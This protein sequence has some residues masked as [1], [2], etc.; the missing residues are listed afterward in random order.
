MRAGLCLSEEFGTLG[1]CSRVRVGSFYCERDSEP[2]TEAGGYVRRSVL[3]SMRF[4]GF[5]WL[6]KGLGVSRSASG[7]L[8]RGGE[9]GATLRRS[10][11]L[12]NIAYPMLADLVHAVSHTFAGWVWPEQ[13]FPAGR[14]AALSIPRWWIGA[15][16]AAF[17]LGSG[18]LWSA[19]RMVGH[20][21]PPPSPKSEE[22][23]N[24]EPSVPTEPI[25]RL[26]VAGSN[27]VLTQDNIRYCLF[28]QVRLE[29][30][31]PLTAATDLTIFDALASDWNARCARAQYP[32]TER[33][34]IGA[35]L[36]TR[37]S[38]L[39]AQGREFV[40]RWRRRMAVRIGST[41]SGAVAPAAAASNSAQPPFKEM[42]PEMSTLPAAVTA[43]MF[44][45]ETVPSTPSRPP[46]LMLLHTYVAARVQR[47]LNELGYTIAPADGTWG[48]MSRTA[49]RRFK[50]A[51]GLL[52]DDALDAET[53]ARLFS[54]AAVN[55][56]PQGR[57]EP[58]NA[59]LTFEA[60]YPPPPG[61]TMNPLNR[62]DASWIQRRLAV[63]GYYSGDVGLWTAGS[64]AA[65]REFKL[66][67]HLPN[68]D[69][70]DAATEAAL[71]SE[72]PAAASDALVAR[73]P[74][75]PVVCDTE[76]AAAGDV[77]PNI[78]MKSEDSPATGDLRGR[79]RSDG[80][81]TEPS[82]T[83]T[84]RNVPVALGSAP[85][86]A[87][88]AGGGRPTENTNAIAAPHVAPRP[89]VPVPGPRRSAPSG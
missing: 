3:P 45:N 73:R 57:G 67:N 34:A 4:S 36:A 81:V 39:E 82:A 77:I 74:K 29:A 14:V 66:T 63:L 40:N 83:A 13:A 32:S 15:A 61:A 68:D 89:P 30:L 8:S 28:Q 52:W 84:G 1:G 42:P 5:V 23:S 51:N 70:W 55:R 86:A 19:G 20:L 59:V 56:P 72:A 9:V 18:V 33:D 12:E 75:H 31:G 78:G 71:N 44:W 62:A 46:S 58:D 64:R 22:Q 79:C 16:A 26:P 2:R 65:L 49:L 50:Q 25:E 6:F 48:P 35:E 87:N 43:Q 21:T 17:L 76:A 41:P 53:V 80:P 11:W 37:R 85:V 60:F 7:D 10:A 54:M 69:E 27:I 24:L 47:R 38:T 88:A